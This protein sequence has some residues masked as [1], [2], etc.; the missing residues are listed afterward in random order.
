VARCLSCA[1]AWMVEPDW[2]DW[3]YS[4]AISAL[5]T[6]V[7]LRNE[8]LRPVVLGLASFV[9]NSDGPFLDFG[10]GHGLFA[11]M[12]RDVGLDYFSE[13]PYADNLF[14]DLGASRRVPDH[15]RMI[16][17]F[18]VLEHLREPHDVLAGLFERTSVVLASTEVLSSRALDPEW[19]YFGWEGGQHILFLS[20]AGL[21][22]LA[23]KVGANRI[24]V[25]SLHL[26]FRGDLAV[27]KARLVMKLGRWLLPYVFLR[28]KFK[29]LVQDD[30]EAIRAG[31]A[32]S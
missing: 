22:S 16:T 18:E 2:L 12:M 25:G 28:M 4:R 23:R 27:W 13:D 24:S 11:R 29:S 19:W 6:G 3:A 9:F 26:F 15:L 32:G 30:F 14:C 8:L 1:T 5:D 21:D 20:E 7:V 10:G 31:L 17:C